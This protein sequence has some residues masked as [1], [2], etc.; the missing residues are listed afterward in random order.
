MKSSKVPTQLHCPTGLSTNA[1][2]IATIAVSF[3][4]RAR[5]K[6]VLGPFRP[7]VF[8]AA[9]FRIPP[10]FDIGQH[11]T[12]P[13]FQS[14]TSIQLRQLSVLL[15]APESN[16][17]SAPTFRTASPSTPPRG[18]VG[19]LLRGYSVPPNRRW[20]S[21]AAIRSDFIGLDNSSFIGIARDRGRA[22]GPI[23]VSAAQFEREQDSN[24]L[25]KVRVARS[26]R[27]ARSNFSQRFE[28]VRLERVSSPEA[29]S[30]P[31]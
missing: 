24:M 8:A 26:I 12:D 16:G 22:L 13:S 23:P 14:L 5:P 18:G 7:S 4:T 20:L 10:V 21:P 27:V 11:N 17:M 2:E 28:W 6:S 30:A 9:K 1:V 29:I 19:R 25:A 31:G 15:C 3:K